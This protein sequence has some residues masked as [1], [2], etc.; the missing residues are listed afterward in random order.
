[1]RMRIDTATKRW[2]DR[3][4]DEGERKD[5]RKGGEKT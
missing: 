3:M 5:E 2:M 4:K 1:M